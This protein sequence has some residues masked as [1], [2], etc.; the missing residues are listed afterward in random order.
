M[1]NIVNP[2]MLCKNLL[3]ATLSWRLQRI[4][5]NKVTSARFVFL[6][7]QKHGL[8]IKSIPN[9]FS[10]PISGIV[11]FS[12]YIPLASGLA[13]FTSIFIVVEQ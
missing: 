2:T 4:E 12:T 10:L 11:F 6:V 5:Q 3:E 13:L 1:M 8:V 9:G 7:C